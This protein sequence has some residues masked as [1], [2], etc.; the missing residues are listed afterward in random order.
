VQIGVWQQGQ[1]ASAL[2]RGVHLTLVVRFGA[3]QTCW[4]DLAVFLD[5]VFQGVDVFVVD[6]FNASSGE[7]AELLRLNRG[8][9]AYAFLA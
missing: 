2:D 9:V 4:H 8:F 3:G 5:E 1:E 7:A 6:L